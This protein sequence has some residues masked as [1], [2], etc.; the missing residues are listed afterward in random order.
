MH[1]YK[2]IYDLPVSLMFIAVV[3][4]VIVVADAVADAAAAVVS[5][6]KTIEKKQHPKLL[7][8]LLQ[9]SRTRAGDE[10]VIVQ[11]YRRQQYPQLM[12]W[13]L[14]RYHF[15]CCTCCCCCCCHSY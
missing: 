5:S 12:R 7:R 2:C 1:V 10:T 6:M 3:F 9:L 13:S 15:R 8:L 11:G 14:S 4:G